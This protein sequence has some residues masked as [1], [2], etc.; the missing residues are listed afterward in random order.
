MNESIFDIKQIEKITG[1]I[2]C[3]NWGTCFL[4]SNS[5]AITARHVVENDFSNNLS[6]KFPNITEE[7]VTGKVIKEDKEFDIALIQLDKEFDVETFPFS[8]HP[9]IRNEKWE[10]YGFPISKMDSGHISYGTISRTNENGLDWDIDI[11]T[12]SDD[13]ESHSGMSGS[14]LIVEGKIIG[15]LIKETEINRTIYAIS[16]IKIQS[17]LKDNK[18]PISKPNASIPNDLINEVNEIE[19]NYLAIYGINRLINSYGNGFFAVTGS[20]GAGKTTLAAHFN[21]LEPAKGMVLGKYFVKTPQR[22]PSIFGKKTEFAYWINNVLHKELYNELPAKLSLNEVLKSLS[23]KFEY[24]SQKLL[25]ESKKGIII[26]DGLDHVKEIDEFYC[27]L[28]EELPENIF[29]LNFCTSEKILPLEYNLLESNIFKIQPLTLGQCE[30]FIFH[31]LEKEISITHQKLIARKS[32]G[33]PLYLRY[34]VE[35]VKNNKSTSDDFIKKIP[36]IG[37]EIKNYYEKIWRDIENRNSVLWFLSTLAQLRTSIDENILKLL[38]PVENQRSYIADSSFS[39]HLLFISN[40]ELRIYHSSFSEFIKSKTEELYSIDINTYISKYCYGN[41]DNPFSITNGIYHGLK[42]KESDKALCN[43]NQE[44]VDKCSSLHVS[45]S[46]IRNDIKQVVSYAIKQGEI[47]ELIRLKLLQQRVDFRYNLLFD[48]CAFELADLLL[49]LNKPK[50]AIKYLI[51]DSVL[52]VPILDSVYFLNRLYH[53]KAKDEAEI[54]LELIKETCISA[55]EKVRNNNENGLGSEYPIAHLNAI[56]L[57]YNSNSQRSRDETIHV[58]KIFSK[59]FDNTK[60]S[61]QNRILSESTGSYSHAYNL[62]HIENYLSIDKWKEI[63][64]DFDHTWSEVWALSLIQFEKFERYHRLSRKSEI[65]QQTIKDF[66]FFV[67]KYGVRDNHIISII[68]CLIRKSTRVDL[69]TK[70][71]D[72]YAPDIDLLLRETNGVDINRSSIIE[73][74]ILSRANG[75]SNARKTRI[76]NRNNNNWEEWIKVLLL[77]IGEE[78][79][80]LFRLKI[81]QKNNVINENYINLK[82][83]V[84][85]IDFTLTDRSDWDRSYHIPETTFPLI[86]NEIAT[87]YLEFYPEN[88]TDLLV[89]I[90]NKSIGQFGLY[91]EGYRECLF[92]IID[93]FLIAGSCQKHKKEIFSLLVLLE[94]HVTK[95]IDNR[96]ERTPLLLRIIDSYARIGNIEKVNSLFNTMLKTSHGPG[97]YKDG[98]FSLI[99]NA[100]NSLPLSNKENIKEYAALLDIASGEMTFQRYVTSDRESFIGE[101]TQHIG[102]E[103]AIE[104]LKYWILPTP[105]II[106]NNTERKSIDFVNEKGGYKF[107]ARDIREQQGVLSLLNYAQNISPIIK[108]AFTELFI[109]DDFHNNHTIANIQAE[110]LNLFER[111]KTPLYGEVYNRLVI[112]VNRDKIKQHSNDYLDRIVKLLS[113]ETVDKLSISI[114]NPIIE[115]LKDKKK[116]DLNSPQKHENKKTSYHDQLAHFTTEAKKEL[117]IGN[118]YEA[119][120]AIL[121]GLEIVAEN[122]S[123]IWI[124]YLSDEIND[125]IQVLKTISFTSGQLVQSLEKYIIEPNVENW[126]VVSQFLYLLEDK[127]LSNQNADKIQ[128]HILDHFRFLVVPDQKIIDGYS[129]LDTNDNQENNIEEQ[130]VDLLIWFLNHPYLSKKVQL[131]EILIW[132][133]QISPSIFIPRIIKEATAQKP[134][135]S[136]EICSLIL[137]KIGEKVPELLAKEI[138]KIDLKAIDIKHFTIKYNLLNMLKMLAKQSVGLQELYIEFENSFSSIIQYRGSCALEE[139]F[140]IPVQAIIDKL[141][142]NNLLDGKVCKAI[143]DEIKTMCQPLEMLEVVKMDK[144]IAQSF[145]EQQFD[146]TKFGNYPYYLKHILNISI[147]EN[148]SQLQLDDV[149]EILS[150]YN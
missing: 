118:H 147:T 3:N 126:N 40:K 29:I 17:F 11:Q 87:I 68:D 109:E 120:K 20:P 117:E 31:Q 27:L 115:T 4:V 63:A 132:C 98:Q 66:E 5:V 59:L 82:H 114:D 36:S 52:V 93:E 61:T 54:L 7:I 8:I 44:W 91:T 95:G 90:Q 57:S 101:I 125:A 26:I 85:S 6:V 142:N 13:I 80:Q 67:E 76:P 50:D 86:W 94:E 60:S 18:I 137:L 72:K 148:V 34:L 73:C 48:D 81:E 62:F 135:I 92:K 51:R 38:L 108:W 65:Y 112:L 78:K 138:Q 10:A 9:A 45:P 28:P 110:I 111:T 46:S 75:Y 131:E 25:A 134:L 96:L 103:K 139:P 133:S 1:Q 88:I 102:F 30:S 130:F 141:D 105:E 12:G 71:I 39:K 100:L 107:G 140:L 56:A 43:C 41:L 32:E 106:K 24:V 145:Y 113:E 37:G 55:Y 69:A 77:R 149:A 89:L 83:L 35:F 21:Y 136:S 146:Y 16:S 58:S 74:T 70:V 64:K 42:S 14:A 128:A 122:R 99:N 119:K 97:W 15:V 143:I 53:I 129:W 84:N 123:T 49:S 33:H 144:F 121:K 2:D 23:A 79:G 104:L 150:S 127:D 124:D 116:E 47:S 19:E 22:Q